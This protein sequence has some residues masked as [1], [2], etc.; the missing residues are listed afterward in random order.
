MSGGRQRF[1]PEQAWADNT[2]LDKARGLLWP[3]KEKYGIGLSWGDLFILAANTA[4]ES[5]G[6]PVLG[7]CGGRVDADSG[8]VELG[9]TPEQEEDAPCKVNGECRPPLGSTTIGLI[10]LSEC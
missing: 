1:L 4:I 2:N 6:G 8:E 7:F 10:Y 3:I 5:M 9:P